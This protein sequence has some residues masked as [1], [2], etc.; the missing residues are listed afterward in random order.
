MVNKYAEEL[1]FFQNIDTLESECA[2][3]SR[4]VVSSRGEI[5][6]CDPGDP[7]KT[8][9]KSREGRSG[10]PEINVEYPV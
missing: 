8:H 10:D 6:T 2:T 1:G 5:A 7:L 9:D 4:R 3:N